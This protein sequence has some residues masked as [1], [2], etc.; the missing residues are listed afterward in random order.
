MR[1]GTTAACSDDPLLGDLLH[2]RRKDYPKDFVAYF[3]RRFVRKF[4]NASS[5]HLVSFEVRD[6]QET[7]TGYG[8][9]ARRN[10]SD[11]GTLSESSTAGKRDVQSV[12]T[13][14]L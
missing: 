5:H 9:W 7:I 14:T 3:R 13:A 12:S 11:E 4:G 6:G 1:A 10:A 2:P 8:E